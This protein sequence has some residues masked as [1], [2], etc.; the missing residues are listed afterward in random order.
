MSILGR[1]L[2]GNDLEFLECIFRYEAD[3]AAHNIVVEVAAI[4]ADA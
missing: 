4:H 2:V 3:W 1:K